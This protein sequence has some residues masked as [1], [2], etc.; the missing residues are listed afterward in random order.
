[1]TEFEIA[2]YNKHMSIS[3]SL[4]KKPYR[5]REKFDGF[6]D[7][8][9]YQYIKKLVI[10]FTKYSE[11]NIDSYFSS[12]YKLYPDVEYFDLQYFASPRGIK[13]YTIYKQ[14][15]DR[16]SPEHHLEDVKKSLEFIAKFCISKHIFLDDYVNYIDGSIHP[17]W[18][19]HLKNNNI[20]FYSLMEFP[21]VINY[22]SDIPEEEQ[23]LLLG[24]TV[25]DFFKYKTNYLHS[26]LRTYLRVAHAGVRGFV[27]KIVT[28]HLKKPKPNI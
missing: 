7:D 24:K 18:V 8:E 12:P 13:S 6:E 9:R 21:N 17:V 23:V 1:M 10:F 25:E 27:E 11:V 4:R 16:L 19:Y 26:K 20:N 5:T 2:I 15:L 22:I 14:E 3:R 28:D